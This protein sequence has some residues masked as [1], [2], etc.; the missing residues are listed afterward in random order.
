MHEC[1]R[2]SFWVSQIKHRNTKC[3]VN[4]A[5]INTGKKE[6]YIMPPMMKQTLN[7]KI[8]ATC[9]HRDFRVGPAGL[10]PATNGL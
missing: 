1:L 4:D 5:A 8:P 3:K 9:V 6:C 10:E 2:N 7:K